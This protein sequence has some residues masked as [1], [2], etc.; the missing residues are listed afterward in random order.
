MGVVRMRLREVAPK[1]SDRD[2]GACTASSHP[3]R[4]T[5]NNFF[6]LLSTFCSEHHRGVQG[7]RRAHTFVRQR[8]WV[9]S[10]RSTNVF[11]HTL[12]SCLHPLVSEVDTHSFPNGDRREQVYTSS[13]PDHRTAYNEPS[14]TRRHTRTHVRQ[15]KIFQFTPGYCRGIF[16]RRGKQSGPQSTQRTAD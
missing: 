6:G 7:L 15:G 4:S 13:Q 10:H 16:L 14:N 11:L 3:T 5:T 12:L 1:R 8:G 9:H 2:T